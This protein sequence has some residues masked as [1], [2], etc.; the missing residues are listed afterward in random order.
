MADSVSTSLV[1]N[2]RALLINYVKFSKPMKI[3]TASKSAEAVGIGDFEDETDTSRGVLRNI[4]YVPDVTVNIL[5]LDKIMSNGFDI[6]MSK[7]FD[8]ILRDANHNDFKKRGY[9]FEDTTHTW[10]VSFQSTSRIS[11]SNC[12]C[13]NRRVA[14]SHGSS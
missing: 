3:V 10:S 5:S 2:D 9:L 1:T 7:P 6:G 14:S 11:T 12:E 13:V 8:I 4:I